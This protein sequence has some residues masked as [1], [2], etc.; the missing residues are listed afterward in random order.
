MRMR[1]RLFGVCSVL[2]VER[3]FY[4][5]ISF[6]NNE[7]HLY[8]YSGIYKGGL[9]GD[10]VLR[11]GLGCWGDGCGLSILHNNLHTGL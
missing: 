6:V 9:S 10:W 11:M 4:M 3:A 1:A 5:S 7:R 8:P 2:K